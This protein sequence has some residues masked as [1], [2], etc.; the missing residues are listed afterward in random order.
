MGLCRMIPQDS[1]QAK[2]LIKSIP[3]GS[4]IMFRYSM[5][6]V[7]EANSND[8]NNSN[9]TPFVRMS[10]IYQGI[11]TGHSNDNHA[12]EVHTTHV[13]DPASQEGPKKQ[14][15]DITIN[16]KDLLQQFPMLNLPPK[17]L[18]LGVIVPKNTNSNSKEG[19][20]RRKTRR[21]QTRRHRKSKKQ[22]KKTRTRK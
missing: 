11:V 14:E 6:L 19:G 21:H 7:P 16:Y 8:N 9:L 12:L 17:Y 4:K 2:K 1:K 10:L 15:K 13:I 18:I 22:S 20:G 3:D 5:I